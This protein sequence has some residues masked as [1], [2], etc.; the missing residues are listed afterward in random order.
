MTVAELKKLLETVPDE[1]PIYGS[2][3]GQVYKLDNRGFRVKCPY[4]FSDLQK[5]FDALCIDVDE[6]DD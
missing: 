6:C 4:S 2:A 3:E 5:R 1:L